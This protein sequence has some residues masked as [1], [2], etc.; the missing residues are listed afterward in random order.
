MATVKYGDYV[1]SNFVTPSNKLY[2]RNSVSDLVLSDLASTLQITLHQMGM[3]LTLGIYMCYYYG[4]DS[5][6]QMSLR[7][8]IGLAP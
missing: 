7:C 4:L 8:K 3:P 6:G 2:N 5:L 1:H